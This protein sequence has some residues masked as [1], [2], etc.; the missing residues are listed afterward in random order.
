[1]IRTAWVALLMAAPQL[2]WACPYCAGRNHGGPMS[3]VLLGVMIALPFVVAGVTVHG[4]RSAIA[5]AA[6]PPP[7]AG[8][9]AP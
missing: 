2:A 4:I 5:E 6:P 8:E 9:E 3:Q 1:M 7:T